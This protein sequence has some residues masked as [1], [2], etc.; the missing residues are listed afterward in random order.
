M[1]ES[2]F[3]VTYVQKL[4]GILSSNFNLT[5]V[6]PSQKLSYSCKASAVALAV[7]L[8]TNSSSYTQES[9]YADGSN[10]LCTNIDGMASA[11][12]EL[13]LPT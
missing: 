8:I 4:S 5:T 11:A 10:G 12:R 7:R 6:Y 1:L 9:F 2:S 3:T 13:P